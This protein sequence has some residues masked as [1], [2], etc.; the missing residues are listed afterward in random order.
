MLTIFRKI[1]K[2]LLGKNRFTAYIL[3]AIGEIILVVIGI[4]IALQVNNWNTEKALDRKQQAFVRQLRADLTQTD[5][6]LEELIE[7]FL[8]R[9]KASQ[10]VTFSYWRRTPLLDTALIN[11]STPMSNRRYNPTLGTAR[12]LINSGNIDIIPSDSLRKSIIAYVDMAD[13]YIRDIQRYEETYYR[14][15][16]ELLSG[17][18]DY[19]FLFTTYISDWVRG[20][21]ILYNRDLHPVPADYEEPPFQI[22]LEEVYA[23]PTILEA[24]NSLLI[25]HRNTSYRYTALREETQKLIDQIVKEGY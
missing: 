19:W 20:D 14:R 5:V 10:R 25:A 23:N 4:L 3:Y 8:V 7:F 16:Q 22:T 15:G 12:S 18:M 6:E 9:A 21:S 13:G 2:S 17:E 24:Y 11:F 1:R